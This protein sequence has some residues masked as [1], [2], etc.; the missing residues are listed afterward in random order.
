MEAPTNFISDKNPL[1]LAAPPDWW[2]KRLWDFDDSLVVIPS[3]QMYVYRLAQRRTPDRKSKLVHELQGGSDSQMLASYG[4]VPVTSIVA[5]CKWDN[6]LMWANLAGRMPSRNGGAEAYEAKLLAQ[7]KQ[8]ELDQLAQR[9]A[10]LDDVGK[11]SF[12]FY[13]LKRG[14]RSHLWSPTIKGSERLPD[15]RSAAIRI[16]NA[17]STKATITKI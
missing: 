13:N 11:D 4:L 8:A 10:M 2:L 9:D 15:N 6:P 1:A 17:N 14:V 12:K 16:K 5:T 7:E 3:R